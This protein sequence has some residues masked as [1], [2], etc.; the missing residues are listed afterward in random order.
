MRVGRTGQGAAR[1]G[2]TRAAAPAL[3]QL[4]TW[5][6]L[7]AL[8]KAPLLRAHTH[9]PSTHLVYDQVRGR[10]PA[11]QRVAAR[12]HAHQRVCRRR[13]QGGDG[14]TPL[15]Q[16]TGTK[17]CPLAPHCLQPNRQP[18]ASPRLSPRLPSARPM[19][20]KVLMV[21]PPRW[22]AASP[23]VPVTNVESRGSARSMCRSSSDLPV[24]AQPAG[25]GVRVL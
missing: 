4:N 20:A 21:V 11:L 23:V 9:S 19:P 7:S 1:H 14:M 10:A 8:H 22:H 17:R 13:G 5:P 3:L 16:R 2:S 12:R 6:V 15:V 25:R 18:T 24:P